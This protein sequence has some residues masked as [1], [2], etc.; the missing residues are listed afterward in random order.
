VRCLPGDARQKR[1]LELLVPEAPFAFQPFALAGAFFFGASLLVAFGGVAVGRGCRGSPVLLAR[2]RTAII[3]WTSAQSV[4]SI[5]RPGTAEL[6]SFRGPC[7]RQF[8]DQRTRSPVL[9]GALQRILRAEWAESQGRV[10]RWR[11]ENVLPRQGGN[12]QNVAQV[13]P[14][15]QGS[16]ARFQGSAPLP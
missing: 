7:C 5:R 3:S 1:R 2:C 14:R 10:A 8:V 16:G 13:T 4:T 6:S 15:N 9:T 12:V 11:G